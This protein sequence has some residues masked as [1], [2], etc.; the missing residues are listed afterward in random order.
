MPPKSQRLLIKPHHFLCI[1]GFKGKGYSSLFVENF[2]NLVTTLTNDPD[3]PLQ[4]TFK[5]DHICEPC[6][7]RQNRSC[8][9]QTK[10]SLLDQNHAKI[11]NLHEGDRLSWNQAKAKLAVNMSL[12]NFHHA[13][14]GCEWKALGFCET[15]LKNLSKNQI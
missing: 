3:E 12:E 13:C 14:Q 5:S 2:Q 1:L 10:I 4:V 9:Q 15:A 8:A 6:P 11:L 7:Q